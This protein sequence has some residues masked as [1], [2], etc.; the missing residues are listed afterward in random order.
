M[1]RLFGE[2]AFRGLAR[3]SVLV[4]CCFLAPKKIKQSRRQQADVYEN[5]LRA[6]FVCLKQTKRN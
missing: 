2:H 4:R 6:C 3:K 5:E 1:M